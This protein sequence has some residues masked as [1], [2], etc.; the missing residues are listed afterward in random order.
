MC[1]YASWS[2]SRLRVQNLQE[3][4]QDNAIK[5]EDW[6]K[7]WIPNLLF[8]NTK[9]HLTTAALEDEERSQVFVR[10]RGEPQQDDRRRLVQNFVYLGADTEIVKQNSYT[11]KFLCAFD[12]TWYPFDIQTCDIAFSLRTPRPSYIDFRA[13]GVVIVDPTF[14]NYNISEIRLYGTRMDGTNQ[15]R[16]RLVLNR[17]LSP[18]IFS[19]FIPTFILTIIN[20][21][22]NF[23]NRP[24]LYEVILSV[25][26]TIL[27]TLTSLFIST[28]NAL[29]MTTNIKMIEIWLFAN[30]LYPFIVI[31]THTLIHIIGREKKLNAQICH[32]LELFGKFV[33]PCGKVI[34][35]VIY[36]VVGLTRRESEAS[37]MMHY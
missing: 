34:F 20:Q 16:L 37:D 24:D 12:L 19:N 23:L 30:F 13:G 18:I 10:R 27:M 31:T 26:A 17:D 35:L 21:Y 3:C 5:P 36:F 4:F 7:L 6:Q 15:V 28:L 8:H 2:D 32:G 9:R 14:Q 29:P 11:V 33:L 22:T 25:N 1:H